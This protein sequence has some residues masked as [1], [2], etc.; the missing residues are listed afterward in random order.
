M[1]YTI[2]FKYAKV[3]E[4]VNILIAINHE[5]DLNYVRRSCF[6]SPFRLPKTQLL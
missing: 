5:K 3:Y 1:S 4:A 6:F 2:C